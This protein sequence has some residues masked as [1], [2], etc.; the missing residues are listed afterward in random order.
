[1]RPNRTA[2][3]LWITGAALSAVLATSPKPAGAQHIPAWLTFHGTTSASYVEIPHHPAFNTLKNRITI[4]AWVSISN[5]GS[6]PSIIG[7]GYQQTFWVGIC[8]VGGQPTLRS[9]LKGGGSSRDGGV[10]TSGW[11][12]V[13]VVFNGTHR[14]HYINGVQVAS[15]PETGPLPTNSSPI[16]IGSD[17]NW[18]FSPQGAINGVR[19][20][21]TART[22]EQLRA[23]INKRIGL[24]RPAGLVA[25]WELAGSA[26][27]TYGRN[28]GTLGGSP[29]GFLTFPAGPPC[30]TAASTSTQHCLVNRYLV[31]ARNRSAS[32]VVTPLSGVRG[33]TSVAFE[34]GGVY[35][36]LARIFG[37]CPSVL[38]SAEVT[39][40]PDNHVEVSVFDTGAFTNH[41][42]FQYPDDPSNILP[43]AIACPI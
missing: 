3:T 41:L 28:D 30:S 35:T 16:R 5:S 14:L 26:L 21:K 10:V 37:G 34:N 31:T 40:F 43:A 24:P 11:Q 15:F 32:G 20:W 2:W 42:V 29:T 25:Q 38:V 23:F 39:G 13:A 19:I 9:Y 6:C 4:E 18:N 1:L 22:Q 7:K 8:S 33:A 36:T 27:D 17:V 12:H